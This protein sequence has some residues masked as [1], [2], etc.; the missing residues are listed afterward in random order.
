MNEGMAGDSK[1]QWFVRGTAVGMLTMAMINAISYFLRSEHWGSLVGDH[2][3]GR[4]SLGFPLV[5]WEDGQTY[6][7]MFV[8][9][10]MLGLNLLFA[11]FIGAIVGTFAASKSTP[12]NVM[13]A[14]MHDH[15]PTDHLQ[16]I[17]FTL[18]SLLITTTLVA[19][20]AMLANN[21]AARP[22]TLIAIYAA[23]PTFL[24]AIAFL[25]RR[26]SW[27]KRVAIIIP[28]TVCLIAVAIAV[29]IALGMEFDKV[30]MGVFLCW[31]PQSA[32]GALAIS[33]W[34]LLSYFRSHPSPYRES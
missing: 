34:I 29:G 5:V 28:A 18:R 19:V 15:S 12:L 10:P 26:I 33:T 17:Q 20:V 3:T 23:G 4:E 30:L 1:L 16:P 2:S 22:E 32:L 27:Q 9:Y 6:G 31:T 14:S 21:Y 11:T 8:D 25:P 24:V 7:G 13:M